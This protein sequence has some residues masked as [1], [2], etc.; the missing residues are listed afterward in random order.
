MTKLNFLKL[1][2]L[3]KDMYL[4]SFSFY[5]KNQKKSNIKCF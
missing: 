3:K 1:S 2:F 5:D 4:K